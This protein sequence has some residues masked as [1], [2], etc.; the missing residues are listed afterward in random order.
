MAE[1]D[2][3][4]E[5][6]N[7]GW[8]G[9]DLIPLR[10][11]ETPQRAVDRVYEG[12]VTM[13]FGIGDD[14]APWGEVTENPGGR[15]DPEFDSTATRVTLRPDTSEIVDYPFDLLVVGVHGLAGRVDADALRDTPGRRQ[16]PY[17]YGQSEETAP[18]IH[19]DQFQ[20]DR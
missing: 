2:N 3:R 1:G 7:M 19:E 10:V 16:H 20:Y 13:T 5:G 14:G 15:K 6:L 12:G 8:G 17:I 9:I 18:R 4:S 11:G